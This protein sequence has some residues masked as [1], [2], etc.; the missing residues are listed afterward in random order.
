MGS[1][2]QRL[3]RRDR[4]R[5]PGYTY[6]HPDRSRIATTRAPD[7][8]RAALRSLGQPDHRPSRWPT[9][10]SFRS[11]ISSCRARLFHPRSTWSASWRSS[12]YSIPRP[13][14]ITSS[15]PR[16]RFWSCWPPRSF[17]P[18]SNFFLFLALYLFFAMAAFTSSEIRRS[19]AEAAHGGTQRI[20]PVLPPPGCAYGH[21]HLRHPGAHR[22]ALLHAAAHRRR[23]LS[24]PGSQ[25]HSI[26]PDSPTR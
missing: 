1:G 8:R 17:P 25:A 11:I 26:C 13:T 2:D 19:P 18:S 20:A 6:S 9:S 4:L 24:S 15:W 22:R 21:H 14:A 23:R 16:S 7:R 5:L 10:L 3:S 12:R